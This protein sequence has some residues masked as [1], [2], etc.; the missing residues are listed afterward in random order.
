MWVIQNTETGKFVAP[1]G[2]KSSYTDD[3]MK[4]QPYLE[5]PSGMCGNEKPVRIEDLM[6]QPI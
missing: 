3:L 5:R 2:S 1:A 6:P 4:A